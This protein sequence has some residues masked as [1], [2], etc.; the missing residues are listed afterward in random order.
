MTYDHTR[1]ITRKTSKIFIEINI[2]RYR[3]TNNRQEIFGVLAE[4]N[5][6]MVA[7]NEVLVAS[8]DALAESDGKNSDV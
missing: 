7:F 1:E 2:D 5:V 8:D 6:V 3:R 4:F